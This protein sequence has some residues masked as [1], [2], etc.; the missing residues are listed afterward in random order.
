MI[1]GLHHVGIGVADLDKTIGDY[2]KIGFEVKKRFTKDDVKARAAL[3]VKG[4]SAI[5]LFEFKDPVNE[6]AQKISNHFALETDNLD[7]DL[8]KLVDIGYKVSIPV[9][10]GVSVKRFVYVEDENNNQIE[11]VE[12]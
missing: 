9:A 5:E 6:L 3:V 7:S 8:K 10:E 12:L 2:E 4:N 11:L 1:K